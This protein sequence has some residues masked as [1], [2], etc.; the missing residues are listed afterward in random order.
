MITQIR[1]TGAGGQGVLLAGEALQEAATKCGHANQKGTYTSQVR[2][3]PTLVDILISG[4]K[5]EIFYPYT[6]AG[7]ISFMLSTANNSFNIYK[8]AINPGSIIVIDPNLVHPTADD[9]KMWR[10]VEIPIV[11]IAKHEVGVL[12]TQSTLALAIVVSITKCVSPEVA[13]EA[14]LSKIPEKVWEINRK[15]FNLGTKYAEAA[16]SKL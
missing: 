9:R 8:D 11:E 5:E 15:A 2:G 14:M 4:S 3:G 12:A 7:E 6:I 10:I 16:L 13:L 1:I